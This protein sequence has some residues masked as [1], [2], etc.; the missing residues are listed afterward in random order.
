MKKLLWNAD[1]GTKTSS[2]FLMEIDNVLK[3][4]YAA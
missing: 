4:V 3:E 1:Q 2:P